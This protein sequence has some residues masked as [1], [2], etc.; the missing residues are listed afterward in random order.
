MAIVTLTQIIQR[1][2]QEVFTAVV[3]VAHFPE[4][5]PTIRSARQVTKG[6]IGEGTRFEFEV[7]GFGRSTIELREFERNIRVKL[8]PD[9]KS[10]GGGHRFIFTA[11]GGHARVDHELEM[12]PKGVFRI[13]TPMMGMMARKNL[14][15]T[16]NAL[17][18]YVEAR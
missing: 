2:V 1:P 5:N 18:A 12:T 6:E 10:F 8:V 13:F 16:A 9:T 4:W 17:K 15:D 7:R 11:E 3:N 14:R